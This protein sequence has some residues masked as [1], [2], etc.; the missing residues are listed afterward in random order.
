MPDMFNTF[1]Q[2]IDI[3]PAITIPDVRDYHHFPQV[4]ARV[5]LCGGFWDLAPEATAR[6][7]SFGGKIKPEFRLLRKHPYDQ[8][9]AT[10]ALLSPP[11]KC[12]FLVTAVS[13]YGCIAFE[14][15]DQE[16]RR[17]TF[18][19]SVGLALRTAAGDAYTQDANGE[20]NLEM[21]AGEHLDLTWFKDFRNN[22]KWSPPANV[23]CSPDEGP[24]ST[25]TCR[26]PGTYQIEVEYW[27]T[28][29]D[30]AKDTSI[31]INLTV[32]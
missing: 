30:R 11:D 13:D 24:Q 5:I 12:T 32:N 7:I 3:G 26:T 17:N 21:N 19:F 25:I 4:P 8:T 6:L 31:F 10:I 9:V 27:R 28:F 22:V 2:T 14:A 1:L 15:Y 23:G 29:P 16:S 18:T 20:Y